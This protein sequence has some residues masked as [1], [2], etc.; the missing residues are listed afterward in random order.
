M[1]I[2]QIVSNPHFGIFTPEKLIRAA[3]S[4]AIWGAAAGSAVALLGSDVPLVK[5]DILSNIPIVGGYWAVE[6]SDNE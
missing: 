1:P 5:K 6:Q 2:K 4:L 3:P